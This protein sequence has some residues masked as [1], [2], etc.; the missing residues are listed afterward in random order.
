[1]NINPCQC[2]CS[3]LIVWEEDLDDMNSIAKIECPECGSIVFGC[4]DDSIED[5]NAHR[6]DDK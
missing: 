6:Y 5:W 1:M 3:D 2:G 4:T